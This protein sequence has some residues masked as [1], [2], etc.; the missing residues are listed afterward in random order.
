M[1]EWEEPPPEPSGAKGSGANRFSSLR[2]NAAF[3]A[4][5]KGLSDGLIATLVERI[6][7][8]YGERIDAI[9]LYGSYL[10]GARDAM[11]DLYVLLDKYPSRPRSHGWLGTMLPPNVYRMVAGE[12]A[13]KI[14]VLTTRRLMKAVALD[15]HPYFWVRFAQPQQLLLCRNQRTQELLD[16][17]VA[18]AIERLATDLAP[19]E[20]P[21]TA[22]A[23]W[24]TLF[25]RTYAAEMRSEMPQ[26]R[27]AL[28]TA[29]SA[30]LDQLYLKVKDIAARVDGR[31]RP[32][33]LLVQAVGK[34]LSALRILKSVLTFEN[35]VDYMLW[36]LQRQSG[37]S[38]Q[39][40][41]RQRRYPLLFAW[42]LIW[43]LYRL[44]AFR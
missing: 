20:W 18:H 26:K 28:Y 44:G 32:P 3:G 2:A 24:R 19:T 16:T 41:E 40:S 31:R 17:I 8:R 34:I 25:A 30:Y 15:L 9:I 14:S 1:P 35:P 36:K 27:E 42:P 13:A 6:V 21:D 22:A 39:A 33:W 4:T 7:E 37:V 29:N 23:Y 5:A 43:R 10:H 38:L 11:P 12:R